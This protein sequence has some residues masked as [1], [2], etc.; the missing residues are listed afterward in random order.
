M[1]DDVS[2]LLYLVVYTSTNG[3]VWY[4]QLSSGHFHT[5]AIR[6]D[7]I[8]IIKSQCVHNSSM[9]YQLIEC[10]NVMHQSN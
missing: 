3:D 10:F 7:L 2:L 4:G 9:K 5:S 1:L 6:N 8:S